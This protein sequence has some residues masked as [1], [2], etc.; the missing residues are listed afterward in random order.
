MNAVAY[1]MFQT[2]FSWR[3]EKSKIKIFHEFPKGLRKSH[4]MWVIW[5]LSLICRGTVLD[6]SFSNG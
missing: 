4:Q 1:L 2:P 5:F 6:L 3:S